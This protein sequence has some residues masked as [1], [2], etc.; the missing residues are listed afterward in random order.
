MVLHVAVGVIDNAAGEVLIALRHAD[1]HQG[2]LWEFPGGKITDGESVENA[3]ARE[4]QEELGIHIESAAPW[5]TVHHTYPERTVELH[6][7][8]VSAFAGSPYGREG[9]PLRWVAV[10]QLD[11]GDFPAANRPIID[12]LLRAEDAVDRS[13]PSHEIDRY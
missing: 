10:R 5:L 8:R 13:A 2:G 11:P 1:R 4:L 7:W 3:L 12:A 9:Q 6:V